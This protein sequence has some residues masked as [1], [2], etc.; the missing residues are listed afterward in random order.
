MCD[1]QVLVAGN[2]IWFAKNSDREPQEPQAVLR[3][4]AVRGD[5]ARSVRTTYID[6]PQVPNRHALI[7]SK[8]CWIWGAEMGVNEHG[9]AIGNEAIFSR[10]RS[11]QPALLGMDLL[12]LALERAAD[13]P[14]AIEVI[15]T[16]LE[17]HGQGGPAGYADKDFHY[18]SSFIIADPCQAWVLETAGRR[19][20]AKRVQ[21][22]AAISNALS[23]GDDYSRASAGLAGPFH[24][25]DTR[26][27]PYFAASRSR[28]ELSMA[29][30]ADTAARS[31]TPGFGDFA[32]QLRRHHAGN[33]APLA[34]SNRDL[35]MH[36]AGPIRRSQ[37]TGSMIAWL[38][39]QG[40]RILVTGTSA[41]CLSLFR[42]VDFAQDTHVVSPSTDSAPLWQAWEPVHRAALFDA[43][44]RQRLRRQIAATEQALFAGWMQEQP[45]IAALDQLVQDSS[46]A[47]LAWPRPALR[48]GLSAA[49][50]IWC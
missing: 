6:V 21:G 39:P 3:L 17:A 43:D 37:T 1:T 32:A 40:A 8:P 7:L 26:L 20:A 23:L 13:A 4:P 25:N 9:L 48:R 15:T 36:A 38:R 29:C 46:A 27:M 31:A 18:D 30:L 22:H 14:A 5:T 50:R 33:E 16:L 24:V 28:R 44:Y 41:P 49:R 2:G 11:R 34:G 35:C 47:I 12:R 45:D 19:W 10:Q 42:P